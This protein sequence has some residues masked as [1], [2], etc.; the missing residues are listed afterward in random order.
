MARHAVFHR[1]SV[2]DIEWLTDDAVA[3]TFDVPPALAD[4][5]TFLPG[6]HLTVRAP[7][8]GD[9]LRR[10]YSICSPAGS[11]R[12]RIGVK[13]LSGGAFSQYALSSLAVG[14]ELDVMTPS[15]RFTVALDPANA[16]HYA[17][18]AAGSVITSVLSIIA[19]V[20]AT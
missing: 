5:Y 12:L 9:D 15:G 16:K 17:L 4:D 8:L 14:D 7:Q 19:S 2:A 1:L 11:G 10:N 13:R 18:I 6:Q 3:I 20:L